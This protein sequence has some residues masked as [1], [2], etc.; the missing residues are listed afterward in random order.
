MFFSSFKTRLFLEKNDNIFLQS[1]KKQRATQM[2]IVKSPQAA[3]S[4]DW[5]CLFK[6]FTF[7]IPKDDRYFLINLFFRLNPKGSK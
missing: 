6:V 3:E 5:I 1:I 4:K 7:V 2:Q